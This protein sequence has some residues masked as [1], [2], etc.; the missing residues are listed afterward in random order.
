MLLAMMTCYIVPSIVVIMLYKMTTPVSG[1][2]LDCV[3]VH[4]CVYLCTY[5]Y[6]SSCQN[7]VPYSV[8]VENEC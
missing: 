8:P 3:Y 7:F 4:A 2:R 6:I 5:I 1:S